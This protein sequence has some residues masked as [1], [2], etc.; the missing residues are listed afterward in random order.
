[1][2]TVPKGELSCRRPR[3]CPFHAIEDPG[4]LGRGEVRIEKK[5]RPLR[6]ERFVAAFPERGAFAGGAA[7]L[8]DDRTMDWP[9][10]SP[11]PNEHRLALVRD[12]DRGDVRGPA[13]RLLQHRPD[14]RDGRHPEVLGLVLHLAGAGGSAART[15]PVPPRRCAPMHRRAGRGSMSCPGRSRVRIPPPRLP[16]RSL[17]APMVSGRGTSRL[18]WAL[19]SPLRAERQSRD[20]CPHQDSAWDTPSAPWL[21]RLVQWLTK[22]RR[23]CC[24]PSPRP[25]GHRK[26]AVPLGGQRAPPVHPVRGWIQGVVGTLHTVRRGGCGA[27]VGTLEHLVPST[28]SA[29]RCP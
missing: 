28:L 5:A 4:D 29:S 17:P 26:A 14:G 10:G 27:V 1:M 6:D 2:S 9:A 24:P 7:V 23:G 20:P 15:S 3:P 16:L 18:P 25:T 13:A 21:N 11:F 22:W 19:N 8:P 12:P